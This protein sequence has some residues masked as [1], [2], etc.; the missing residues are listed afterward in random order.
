MIALVPGAVILAAASLALAQEPSSE[1]ERAHPL[2]VRVG[3]SIALCDT[4]TI[5]CPAANAI[6]DDPSIVAVEATERGLAL[7]G[8]K[9]GTTLCSAASGSALG[10]RRLYRVTVRPSSP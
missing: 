1:A 4:G 6:C 5:L 10:A 7:R 9:S 2:A 3:E 8:L